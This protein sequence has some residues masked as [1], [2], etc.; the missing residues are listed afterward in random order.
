MSIQM[1]EAVKSTPISVLV[2]QDLMEP[3]PELKMAVAVAVDGKGG[4]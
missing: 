1:D 3:K 2:E 4:Q